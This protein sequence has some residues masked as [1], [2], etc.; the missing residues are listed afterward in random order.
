MASTFRSRQ[1]DPLAG[2]TRARCYVEVYFRNHK[3]DDAFVTEVAWGDSEDLTRLAR[4]AMLANEA[5][6][7]KAVFRYCVRVYEY[8]I[9]RGDKPRKGARIIDYIPRQEEGGPYG[10]G[11]TTRHA[12]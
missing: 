6:D 3:L 10:H 11:G 7:L 8:E 9:G 5:D 12:A 4:E 1:P 2:M